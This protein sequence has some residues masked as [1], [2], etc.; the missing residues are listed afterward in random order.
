MNSIFQILAKIRINREKGRTWPI[1]TGYRPGFNFFNEKLTSGSIK[2]LHSEFLEPGEETIVEVNFISNE[3][4]G[5][6]RIGTE[7]KFY[8]GPVEIGSGKVLK[9]IGWI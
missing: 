2:L 9:I 6:I 5:D 4:L 8:E 1:R 7:F 3:L